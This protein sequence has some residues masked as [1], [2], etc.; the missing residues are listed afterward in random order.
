MPAPISPI[1]VLTPS[2]AEAR[3]A[4]AQLP[5]ASRF[6]HTPKLQERTTDE[7][8]GHVTLP[9]QRTVP[10]PGGMQHQLVDAP[11]MTPREV[12]LATVAQ[13]AGE[14]VAHHAAAGTRPSIVS[15]EEIPVGGPHGFVMGA[16]SPHMGISSR[17]LDL[18][19]QGID[20][21]RTQPYDTW[22]TRDRQKF[23]GANHVVL[24]EASHAIN[25]A[26]SG[27]PNSFSAKELARAEADPAFAQH[28]LRERQLEEPVTELATSALSSDFLRATYGIDDPGEVSR[29]QAFRAHVSPSTPEAYSVQPLRLQRMLAPLADA[30]RG[31]DDLAI[32]FAEN[33]PLSQRSGWLIDNLAAR[34]ARQLDPRVRE[35]LI[36]AVPAAVQGSQQSWDAIQQHTGVRFA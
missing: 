13:L 20:R 25:H 33:V 6:R 22:D 18:L 27:G 21:L 29:F 8:R 7:L 36:A 4:N 35:S 9:V 12:V 31:I 14:H 2:A 3:A 17:V 24:H 26:S 10:G 5:F 1:S 30:T 32:T 16:H 23:I 28:Y 15:I 11:G 19:E 34:G